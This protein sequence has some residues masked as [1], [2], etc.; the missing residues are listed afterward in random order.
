MVMLLKIKTP[1][2][3]AAINPSQIIGIVEDD[4]GKVWVECSSDADYES[5]EDYDTIV[6][7]LENLGF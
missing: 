1:N 5:T 3:R 4:D 2:G 6:E 7:R